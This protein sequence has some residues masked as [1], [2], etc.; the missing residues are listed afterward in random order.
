MVHQIIVEKFA[1][2]ML[3]KMTEFRL[4]IK[5]NGGT[6]EARNYG[7]SVCTGDFIMIIDGDDWLENDCVEYMVKL[8]KQTNS[9]MAY[10]DHVFTTRD[11]KQIEKDC[12][13][14]WSPGKAAAMIV[15]PYMPLGP[16][17]KIYRK[18]L[19]DENNITFSVPWFGEGLYF[20]T[21]AAQHANHVGVGHRKVY[22][23]RLNNSGSGLTTYK[24]QK[25]INALKNIYT[26]KEEQYIKEDILSNANRLA[27]MEELYIPSSSNSWYWRN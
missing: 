8:I 5:K 9:D 3:R 10:S 6:C 19:L 1:I 26:L 16:W 14:T 11:R 25:G 18:S 15:Y 2:R 27:Y 24:V 22:N 21:T 12:I 13:E 4:F 17:N 23:Y 7:L 20:A